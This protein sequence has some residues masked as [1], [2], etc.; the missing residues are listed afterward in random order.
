MTDHAGRNIIVFFSVLMIALIATA[1]PFLTTGLVL[2]R[3]GVPIH[4]LAIDAAYSGSNG[5]FQS[6]TT[7]GSGTFV[8]HTN[9]ANLY[10]SVIY[11]FSINGTRCA[12]SGPEDQI[13]TVNLAGAGCS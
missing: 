1:G 7:D 11:T 2:E 3:N 9:I 12:I 6:G 4:N 13:I 10:A 5:P 8:A